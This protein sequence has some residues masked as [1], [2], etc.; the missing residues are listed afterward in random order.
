MRALALL[1]LGCSGA[2]LP[3]FTCRLKIV[4]SYTAPPDQ[5][6]IVQAEQPASWAFEDDD[7]CPSYRC[8]IVAP[9]NTV[10]MT[11]DPL[12]AD[13]SALYYDAFEGPREE[14]PACGDV[15]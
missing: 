10:F 4:D 2:G 11:Y 12:T 6:A 14:L 15:P 9:G 1:L 7:L 13:D 3:D 8:A 5:W